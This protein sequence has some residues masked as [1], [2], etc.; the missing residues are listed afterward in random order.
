MEHWQSDSQHP[1]VLENHQCGL[2][3]WPSKSQNSVI[4]KPCPTSHVT[5]RLLFL[6]LSGFLKCSSLGLQ[7]MQQQDSCVSSCSQSLLSIEWKI[8]NYLKEKQLK[9]PPFIYMLCSVLKECLHWCTSHET[10]GLEKLNWSNKQTI[11]NKKKIPYQ[12]KKERERERGEKEG[13]K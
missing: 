9:M 13:K 4:A 8:M 7:M 11:Q 3:S 6:A 5:G 1:K 10:D 12:K 2:R